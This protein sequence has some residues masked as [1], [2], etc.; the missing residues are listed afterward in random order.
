M[1]RSDP[2]PPQTIHPSSV[3]VTL[4]PSVSVSEHG[5]HFRSQQRAGLASLQLV[6]FR[7][8]SLIIY[9]GG[10]QCSPPPIYR[11]SMP[12]LGGS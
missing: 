6:K 4:R 8:Y 2:P 1:A 9:R 3:C 5:T 12:G 11:W 10:E 7:P